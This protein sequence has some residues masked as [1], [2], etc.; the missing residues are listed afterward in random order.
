M[1]DIGLLQVVQVDNLPVLSWK[2]E[3]GAGIDNNT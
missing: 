2:C 1:A 3:G